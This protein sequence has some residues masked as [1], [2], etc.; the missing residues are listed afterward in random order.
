MK[1][2]LI[3]AEVFS[4][5][6]EIFDEMGIDTTE[7]S[8][9]ERHVK[10][11]MK[12]ALELQETYFKQELNSEVFKI[13]QRLEKIEANL[14]FYKHWNSTDDRFLLKNYQRG[15][16]DKIAKELKRTKVSVAGRL[17]YLKSKRKTKKKLSLE[18][19]E[20]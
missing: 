3:I 14:K 11:F 7:I 18:K 1:K 15:N 16:L 20:K 13:T 12:E 6:K 2:H 4:K 8:F 19:Q 9:E 17:S 10:R 5:S